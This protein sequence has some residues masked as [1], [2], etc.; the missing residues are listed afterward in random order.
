[1]PCRYSIQIKYSYIGQNHNLY[2]MHMTENVII[3]IL[4]PEILLGCIKMY[5][6]DPKDREVSIHAVDILVRKVRSKDMRL[7]NIYMVLF[8]SWIRQDL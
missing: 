1:M 2:K 8:H 3:K 7:E 5:S 4:F 6:D